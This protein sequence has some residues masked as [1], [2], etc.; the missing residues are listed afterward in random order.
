M[1]NKG[2]NYTKDLRTVLMKA[3]IGVII[4]LMFG[5]TQDMP[6]LMA[7]FGAGIPFGWN[8][9]GKLIPF[10]LVGFSIP[11]L[12][13]WTIKLGLSG[14]IGVFALPILIVYYVVRIWLEN[15]SVAV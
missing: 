1:N 10:N 14:I 15:R 2:K 13:F 8:L 12:F 6:I 5:V 4:G 7:Y 3:A 9:I 11:V